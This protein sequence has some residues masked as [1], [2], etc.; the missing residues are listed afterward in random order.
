LF[1]YTFYIGPHGRTW[2]IRGEN[3]EY[4]EDF[5]VDKQINT[6]TSPKV[7]VW[8]C[9]SGSGVG[10]IYFYDEPLTGDKMKA[11]Y[12]KCLWQSARKL[13]GVDSDWWLLYDNDPRHKAQVTVEWLNE[14][15]VRRRIDFPPYSPD[16]NPIE[17][18]WTILVSRVDK[19]NATTEEQ[20]KNAITREWDKISLSI[21][22]KLANSMPTR[23]QEVID[24]KGHKT[25]Y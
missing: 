17:N 12:K 13:F 3:E 22:E 7:H 19:H 15:F 20:L 21:C 10:E 9:F 18:V 11:I 23:L 4:D 24:H 1:C 6:S 14:N 5:I 8:A 16:L 25:H 2:V